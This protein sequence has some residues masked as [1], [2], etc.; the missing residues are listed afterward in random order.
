MRA[1]FHVK[2]AEL[3]LHVE[4]DFGYPWVWSCNVSSHPERKYVAVISNALTAPPKGGVKLIAQCLDSKGYK[5][6]IW[7]R[8][9]R[10]KSMW[11]EFD[12]KEH[13]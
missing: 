1:S 10:G 5:N 7:E 9:R 2:V 6:A 8:V 13:L 4:G 12:V 11:V 3:R